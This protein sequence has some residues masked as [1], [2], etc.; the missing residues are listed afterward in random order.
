MPEIKP[1][2]DGC[3]ARMLSIVLCGPLSSYNCL[4]NQM[5]SPFQLF[6]S[7]QVVSEM[8]IIDAY[9]RPPVVMLPC[10]Q[11]LMFHSGLS[12]TIDSSL[13]VVQ[14]YCFHSFNKKETMCLEGATWSHFYNTDKSLSPPSLGPNR[15][16]TMRFIFIFKSKRPGLS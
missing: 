12:V 1:G 6:P 3:K 4:L 14:L 11:A 5:A 9:F 10:V 16:T 2:T 13:I 8:S 7:S 15:N